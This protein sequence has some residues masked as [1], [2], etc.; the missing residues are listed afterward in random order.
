M[1]LDPTLSS[2]P[3]GVSC[4]TGIDAAATGPTGYLGAK[5]GAGV[6]ARIVG[7]MPVHDIY[8]ETHLGTGSVMAK[9]FALG[10]ACRLDIGIEI[11][12]GV[13]SR[14]RARYPQQA[15]IFVNDW[16]SVDF[17]LLLLAVPAPLRVPARILFYHDPPYHPDTRLSHHGYD[18]DYDAVDH[19]RLLS[20]LT[21]AGA[22]FRH[23]VSGYRCAAYDAA[24]SPARGW[25]RIDYQVRTRGPTVTESL[26]LNYP[27]GDPHWHKSAGTDSNDRIRIKRKQ[28]R[29]RAMIKKCP[30]AER[31]ALLDG[32]LREIG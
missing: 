10:A 24:L 14:F 13:A 3:S 2:A 9:K 32:I 29:W 26:W 21:G 16:R 20:W 25:R 17:D 30:P 1:N 5:S 8:I 23:M 6:A 11:D 7:F 31:L 15:K 27:A 19:A 4:A 12:A 22:Q 18:F 28:E